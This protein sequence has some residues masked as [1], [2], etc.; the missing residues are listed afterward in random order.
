MSL[1]VSRFS[2]DGAKIQQKKAEVKTSAKMPPKLNKMPPILGGLVRITKKFFGVTPRKISEFSGI[3]STGLFLPAPK[4]IEEEIFGIRFAYT[5]VEKPM[6][7]IEWN[8]VFFS[9]N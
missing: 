1:V 3:F 7:F 4:E 2:F 5:L 8:F 6:D 9:H